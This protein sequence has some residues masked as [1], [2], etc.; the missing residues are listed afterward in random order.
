MIELYTVF[1]I[2]THS[3][4][5]AVGK[6]DGRQRLSVLGAAQ[7]PTNGIVDPR[8]VAHIDRFVSTLKRLVGY[9][10]QQS[11]VAIQQAWV[12]ITHAA[13]RGEV[14]NAIITFPR[15]D[16]EV[17]WEDLV[18]LRQQAIHRPVP[19]G[20]RL[21][22]AL[23]LW[24]RL[25]HRNG[26][27]DPI[28]M[29]GIRLEGHYYLVYAPEEYLNTLYR[30]FDRAGI[31]VQGFLAAPLMAAESLLT[32]EEK[33]AGVGYVDIGGH[34]TAVIL[35]QGGQ[36]RHF[37]LLPMGGHL[38]TQDIREA[39][40]RILPHQAEVLKRQLGMA[41]R[42]LLKEDQII[43]FQPDS[44][45]REHLEVRQSV[46]IEVIQARF[47]EILDFV[48]AEIDRAGLLRE[49]HAGLYVAGGSA[50]M[51]GTKE[52][53]EYTLG[54]SCHLAQPES[55]I[56]A[57]ISEPFQSPD[58]ANLAAILAVVPTMKDLTLTDFSTQPLSNAT[59]T[60]PSTTRKLRHPNFFQKVFTYLEK[61]IK[62]PQDLID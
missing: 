20:F 32:P 30:C 11:S 53:T 35:Y 49:L 9:L 38:V 8:G 15:A 57:G 59:E 40:R 44:R 55:L 31:A 50:A 62:I 4:R 17:K 25:D 2:G 5:A 41:Y 24:Y 56:H 39:I 19:A 12:G 3:M 1:D 46:L 13:L 60:S 27:S 29:S 52:L 54:V 6:Y 22:H 33:N 37:S 47:Q 48:A 58:M 61:Q 26:L 36:L 23:P 10:Q 34:H 16:H 14:A 45:R 21:I 51:P 18:R 43:T 7:E 42:G 28:G